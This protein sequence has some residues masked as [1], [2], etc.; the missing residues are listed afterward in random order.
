MRASLSLAANIPDEFAYQYMGR[1]AYT[2]IVAGEVIHMIQCIAV[3]VKIRQDCRC[4]TN[5]PIIRCKNVS[6]FMTPRTHIM[7]PEATQVPCNGPLP[8][9]FK[10]DN[11]WYKFIPNPVLGETPLETNYYSR[12]EV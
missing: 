10:I 6:T 8:Q 4:Y 9:F 7:V 1:A 12:L 3:E 5:L 11:L 2:A